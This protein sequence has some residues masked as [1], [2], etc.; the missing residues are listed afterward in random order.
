MNIKDIK[1]PL[2]RAWVKASEHHDWEVANMIEK[3]IHQVQDIE[4]ELN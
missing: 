4:K 1:M 3:I 2:K